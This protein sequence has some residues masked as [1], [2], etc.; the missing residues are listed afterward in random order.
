MTLR[1][2]AEGAAA[3]LRARDSAAPTA[4]DRAAEPVTRELGTAAAAAAT[5]PPGPGPSAT[6]PASGSRPGRTRPPGRPRDTPGPRWPGWLLACSR[7]GRGWRPVSCSATTWCSCP[8]SA[9][10]GGADRADRRAAA[11]RAQRRRGGPGVA[12]AASR[13]PAE[14]HL[15]ADLR[16]GLLRR[17]RAAG[18]RLAGARGRRPLPARLA[19]GVFYAWNPYLAER[20]LIGQW[21]LLLGYAGLPWVLR[22]LA[23][24]RGGPGAARLLCVMPPRRSADSRR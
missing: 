14:A 2:L 8:G 17:R 21:A 24:D 22:L 13:H 11:R 23:P 5:A 6:V 18:P 3:R 1:T 10:L 19:A 16:H 4:A 12:A 9:V 7:S 20:L 15:G